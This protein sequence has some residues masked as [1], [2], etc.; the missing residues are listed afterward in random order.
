[1]TRLQKEFKVKRLKNGMGH[2]HL[3]AVTDEAC[4]DIHI[5]TVVIIPYADGFKDP[6]K[7][8]LQVD[9]NGVPKRAN[10]KFA[11]VSKYIYE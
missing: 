6:I 7:V 9:G 4:E 3:L 2:S 10:K 1:M 8:L 5:G 11:I